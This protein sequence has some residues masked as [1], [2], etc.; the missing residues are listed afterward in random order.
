[1]TKDLHEAL[2]KEMRRL[3][4]AGY[5]FIVSSSGAEVWFSEG[6]GKTRPPILLYRRMTYD[7]KIGESIGILEDLVT[8]ASD[9]WDRWTRRNQQ[10]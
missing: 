2:M 7:T 4:E 8:R 6:L 3:E 1:M 5:R 9:H 10:T